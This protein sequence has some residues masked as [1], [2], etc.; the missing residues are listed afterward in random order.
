MFDEW[1]EMLSHCL[2]RLGPF[3]ARREGLQRQTAGVGV[4]R[5]CH[6]SGGEFMC[7]RDS[8]GQL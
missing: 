4:P 2:D 7:V 8:E 5:D 1:L 3:G 6:N